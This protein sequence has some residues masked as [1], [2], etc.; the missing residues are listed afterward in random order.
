MS[1]KTLFK[2]GNSGVGCS[3]FALQ[4]IGAFI[5]GRCAF[6]LNL[7]VF[8]HLGEASSEQIRGDFASEVA[9]SGSSQAFDTLGQRQTR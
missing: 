4:L 1:G 6:P 3:K 7:Q 9:W 8:G 5:G 2:D